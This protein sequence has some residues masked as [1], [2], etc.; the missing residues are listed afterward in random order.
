MESINWLEILGYFASVLIAVSLMMK[1]IIW[2]RWLNFSGCFLFVIYGIDISAWPVVG[3]NS[4][5]CFINLYHLYRI[6][7]QDD[8]A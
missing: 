1:N 7:K 5:I 3:M 8:G 2:L 4:A 6:Y